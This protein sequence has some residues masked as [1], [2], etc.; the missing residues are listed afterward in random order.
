MYLEKVFLLFNYRSFGVIFS[1]LGAVYVSENEIV[2]MIS[3]G[4]FTN[5]LY[6][7]YTYIDNY[8]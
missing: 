3:A 6:Y 2:W 5:M 1:N 4:K 8:F 7:K